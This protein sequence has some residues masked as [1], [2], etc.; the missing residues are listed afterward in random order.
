MDWIKEALKCLFGESV[1]DKLKAIPDPDLGDDFYYDEITGT[2]LP[3]SKYTSDKLQS[4]IDRLDKSGS[5]ASIV[6]FS[7]KLTTITF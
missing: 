1:D 2:W 3:K 6:K 7:G 4:L 5:A